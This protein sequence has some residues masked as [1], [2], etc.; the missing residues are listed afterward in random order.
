MKLDVDVLKEIQQRLK[1]YYS[2]PNKECINL[3]WNFDTGDDRIE[4][5]KQFRDDDGRVF[6]TQFVSY[7]LEQL[8]T[9]KV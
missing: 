2:E 3:F 8:K 1:C 5:L 6:F 9:L 7:T 4:L